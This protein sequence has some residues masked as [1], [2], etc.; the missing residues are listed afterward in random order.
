MLLWYQR[1]A[2]RADDPVSRRC[3][4][5]RCVFTIGVALILATADGLLPRRAAPRSKSRSPSC[6]G[7]RRSSTSWSACPSGCG[8][9]ILLS[10]MSPFV[11]AYQKLFFYPGVAGGDGLAGR[12]HLRGRA[13]SSSAR[14]WSWRSKI[15][16]RSSSSARSSTRRGGLEAVPAQAQRVGR[17][18]GPLPRPPASQPAAVGRGV[19]G[20]ARTSRCG[21][22]AARRSAWSAG[23]DRAR[24]RS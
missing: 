18:E 8:C 24:A 22:S 15:A 1:A 21:S 23:T 4:R 7:R 20:A 2:R 9:S 11:V 19:L 12:D 16:S 10:P 6:S 5:C 17:A 13:R 14:R 3:S